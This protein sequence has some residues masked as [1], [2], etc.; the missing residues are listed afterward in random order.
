VI[1]IPISVLREVR[2]TPARIAGRNLAVAYYRG[3]AYRLGEKITPQPLPAAW[4]N[5]LGE[6]RIIE[7]DPLLELIDLRNAQLVHSEGLLYFRYRVPGWLGMVAKIPVRPV[8]DTELVVEGTGWLMGE[9]VQVVRRDGR[10]VLRYSGY[11][12][13]RVNRP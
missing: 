2:I 10:E 12:F 8:S 6:Y 4:R 9:T 5:R 7:R 11:E 1:P 3:H 13:Q